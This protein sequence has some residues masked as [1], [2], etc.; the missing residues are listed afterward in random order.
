[1]TFTDLMQ[2]SG[3]IAA[4]RG[5]R[6]VAPENTLL[7]FRK[8]AGR[9]DFVEL[10]VQ[11][12]RDGVAVVIHD[13]TLA[14]TTDVADMHCFANRRPW[15]VAAFSLAELQSLNAADWFYRSD[16]FGSIAAGSDAVDPPAPQSIPTL[17][18]ALHLISALELCVNIELKDVHSLRD[19]AAVVTA[20]VNAV[21]EAGCAGRVLF[22]SFYHPYLPLLK[23]AAPEI[24]VSML[25]E[26]PQSGD[27]VAR[28]KGLGVEGCHCDDA[29]V[30]ESMVRALREAGV[31]VG[32]YTVN[33]P[34]RRKQLFE[35]GVNAVFTD[36]PETD[37]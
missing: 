28:V 2:R 16:P 34:D 10:D 20:I 24:P 19:D 36:H 33:D 21:R 22:S 17:R 3:L 4:H 30:T 27:P 25:V 14:R 15:P 13:D 12:S 23:A 32:V 1:M 26:G 11:F 37:S 35:W 5:N 7:A 9:C 6:A 31:F 29:S 18:E 8:S